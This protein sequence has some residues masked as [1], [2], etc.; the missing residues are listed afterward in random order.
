M[1][2]FFSNGEPAWVGKT[3][4]D[5]GFYIRQVRPD[6]YRLDVR[7]WGSTNIRIIPDLNTLSDGQTVFYS[8][9]LMENE[10]IATTT[11]TN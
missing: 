5:G 11:V 4:K 1:R 2:L 8:V 3:D 7:G 6:T 10:C 9:Q